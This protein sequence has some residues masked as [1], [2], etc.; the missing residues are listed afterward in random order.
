M[1]DDTEDEDEMSVDASSSS[2]NNSSSDSDADIAPRNNDDSGSDA[3]SG[4]S[5][6]DS[7]SESADSDD[8]MEE[9]A[10]AGGGPSNDGIGV[11]DYE[12]SSNEGEE[13]DPDTGEVILVKLEAKK[14]ARTVFK[15]VAQG[16]DHRNILQMR[17]MR[18][19][20][21]ALRAVG[22]QTNGLVTTWLNFEIAK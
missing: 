22:G 19:N 15:E 16:D 11:A 14:A 7:S 17:A 4:P 6:K 1:S 2:S 18:Y 20:T 5:E 9:D 21:I 12:L 8:Q 3:S 13:Y 10:D